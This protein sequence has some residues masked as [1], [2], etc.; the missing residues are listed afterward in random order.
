[1]VQL[2]VSGWSQNMTTSTFNASTV[3][4]FWKSVRYIH[5]LRPL[6]TPRSSGKAEDL[7]SGCRPT[8]L[9][10]VSETPTLIASPKSIS[11]YPLKNMLTNT[12]ATGLAYGERHI[13][14]D[15][16]LTSEKSSASMIVLCNVS[17]PLF[18]K[19]VAFARTSLL[20]HT[21]FL[22]C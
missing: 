1:M 2:K 9:H 18:S 13:S 3:R 4:P 10:R 5:L 6:K 16:W 20:V 19:S 17:N 8:N 15:F 22:V 21:S 7:A 12:A 11:A 14:S